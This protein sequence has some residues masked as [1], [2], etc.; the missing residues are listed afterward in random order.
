MRRKLIRFLCVLMVVLLV[1][2]NVYN[3]RAK[4][5]TSTTMVGVGI[6]ASA[7]V[8]GGLLVYDNWENVYPLL[9][10]VWNNLGD[11]IKDAILAPWRAGEAFV[12]F[13][14]TVWLAILNSLGVFKDNS[15]SSTVTQ[16]VTYEPGAIVSL[17][18][19]GNLHEIEGLGGP[20]NTGYYY[21]KPSGDTL[22]FTI[23][24]TDFGG[25]GYRMDVDAQRDSSTGLFTYV[26]RIYRYL[27]DGSLSLD[28]QTSGQTEGFKLVIEGN[29]VRSLDE[30]ITDYFY[31]YTWAMGRLGN[32]M[33]GVQILYRVADTSVFN[34]P[35]S[36][37]PADGAVRIPIDYSQVDVEA[38][39]QELAG[40][41]EIA[42]PSAATGD[43]E[44]IHKAI[45][46][47][48]KLTGVTQTT[49]SELVGLNKS[50]LDKIG[51]LYD[52]FSTGLVGAVQSI[53]TGVNSIVNA[54]SDGLV[55][56]LEDV[57]VEPLVQVGEVFT[58]KF[59]FSLPW[60]VYRA[61]TGLGVQVNDLPP[62]ELSFYNPATK[63][64]MT[65][66][67]DIEEVF[68]PI[69]ELAPYIRAGFLVMFI[70][71]LVYATREL[72]GGAQ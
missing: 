17:S 53:A 62:L 65:W 52:V 2:V 50:I 68:Y 3:E 72:L 29:W 10:S 26:M 15:I 41:T 54:L 7:L 37:N 38:L 23:F 8:A 59:P 36:Y 24:Y 12:K 35:V 19:W 55:G 33:Y 9:E 14:P 42:I 60:D 20:Y 47:L 63:Q 71:G 11:N 58:T 57:N 32:S 61:V 48:T 56:E 4:A 5:L 30:P 51:E 45:D 67:V 39:S 25:T 40:K 1:T 49:Y 21:I 46:L 18:T 27:N 70:L 22:G 31:L 66:T 13:G 16:V 44:A 6:L 69:V 43:F 28:Y 34:K 64:V